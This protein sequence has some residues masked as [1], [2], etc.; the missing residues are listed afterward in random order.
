M[1]VNP[2]DLEMYKK[3]FVDEML[4]ICEMP[5]IPFPKVKAYSHENCGLTPEPLTPDTMPMLTRQHQ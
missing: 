1:A 3:R 2:K 4:R 5:G